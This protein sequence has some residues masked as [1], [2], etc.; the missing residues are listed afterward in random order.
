M[1]VKERENEVLRKKIKSLA[2]FSE[3][4]WLRNIGK[5]LD[6]DLAFFRHLLC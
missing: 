2:A 3:S 4:K 5:S 1:P 6:L